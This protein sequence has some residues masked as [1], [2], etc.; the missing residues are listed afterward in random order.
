[1]AKVYS[2]NGYSANIDSNVAKYTVPG[3][4]VKL[5]LRKGNVSVVLLDFASWFH[6]NVEPLEQA[7]CG[8]Y[9]KR[10]IEGSKTLSNHASATAIDLNWHKHP[11][12][13]KN[14]FSVAK[15]KKIREKLKEYDGVIRW[16][17][18]YKSRPDDMHFEIN[19]NQAA[20]DKQAARIKN[21]GE[22][23]HP[24]AG[25]DY[26]LQFPVNGV[27]D[28]GTIGKWQHYM[29][30]YTSRQLTPV[31]IRHVQAFLKERVDHRI[32]VDGVW[33]PQTVRGLQ[34]Y[35][36]TPVD[37]VISVPKSKTIIALQR[38]LNEGRF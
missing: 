29:G 17:G 14:T 13:K 2:Q 24:S 38:R 9:A 20:V 23:P 35:L 32:D 26:T 22:E 8:G 3:S 34:R 36:K 12:G 7:Q 6:K 10:P 30:A 25:V 19:K 15:Q 5:N 33:G 11:M 27:L 1:M 16:G 18:D 4:S 28:R 37:G 21:G 31:F